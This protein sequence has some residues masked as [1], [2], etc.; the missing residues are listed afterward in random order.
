MSTNTLAFLFLSFALQNIRWGDAV[1]L[2]EAL[3]E[4][5][6]VVEAGQHRHLGY[7]ALALLQELHAAL[8]LHFADILVGT[9]ARQ[10]LHLAI[11]GRMA[12]RHLVG[13]EGDVDVYRRHVL[14]DEVVQLLHE[15]LVQWTQFW[16]GSVDVIIG[17]S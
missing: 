8:E 17:I 7:V 13:H 14:L 6:D 4:V 16:H 11:E 9:H 10:C 1:L 3:A 12:H 2:L 5:A 15:L